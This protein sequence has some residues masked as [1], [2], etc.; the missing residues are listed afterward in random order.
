MIV[1][2]FHHFQFQEFLFQRTWCL[3]KD[4]FSN[5]TNLQY[6]F[7]FLLTLSSTHFF[8]HSFPSFWDFQN[9]NLVSIESG[10]FN[11]LNNLRWLSYFLLFLR[12]LIFNLSLFLLPPSTLIPTLS[13]PFHL[14]CFMVYPLSTLFTSSHFLFFISLFFIPSSIS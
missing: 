9:N 4:V 2:H 10:T 7:P 6:L 5:L 1:I 14:M 3:G 12:R 13:P 11:G 8:L